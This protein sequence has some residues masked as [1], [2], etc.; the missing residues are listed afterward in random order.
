MKDSIERKIDVREAII[1]D[2]DSLWSLLYKMGK[3]DSEQGV[4][5]RYYKMINS[6]EQTFLL[7]Y[8]LIR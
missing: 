4:K 3:T 8:I 1:D 5:S 7:L 2:W 6:E